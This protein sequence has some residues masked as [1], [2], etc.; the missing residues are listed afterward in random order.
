MQ[1]IEKEIKPVDRSIDFEIGDTV[2]VHYKIIEGNK[3]RIQVYEGIV[4]AIDN[5]G[6]S[7]TFT[8]RKISFEVGVERVFPLYST[9]IAKIE[10]VRKGKARRAK[11]YFLRDRKGKSAKLKEKRVAKSAK[12]EAAP[13]NQ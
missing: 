9:R 12:N 5:K 3:E 4:I 11:L 13:V 8:V 6:I 2:R 7:K 10:T 1:V